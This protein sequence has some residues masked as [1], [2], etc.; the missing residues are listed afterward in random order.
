MH[1]ILLLY[2]VAT[3]LTKQCIFIAK[4][5]TIYSLKGENDR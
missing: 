3:L 2:F 4:F 1:N 5:N